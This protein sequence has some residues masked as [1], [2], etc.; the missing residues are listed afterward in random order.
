MWLK[1]LDSSRQRPRE[2]TP[3]SCPDGEKIVLDADRS[4][5]SPMPR[6]EIDR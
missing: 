6:R 2:L 3:R 4:E 1:L 5:L